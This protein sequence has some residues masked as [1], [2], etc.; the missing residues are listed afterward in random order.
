[1]K[2]RN[3]FTLIELLVVIAIIGMLSSVVLVSLN[4]ARAKSR[5]SK[6]ISDLSQL[7]LAVEL[8]YDKYGSY[9]STGGSWW[10][11]GNP[12]YGSHDYSGVNGW[13]PNLAPEFIGEL[14]GDPNP[15]LAGGAC[16]LYNSNGVDYMII[17]HG[18]ME[19][20]C[21]GSDSDTTR[22]PGDE[23]NPTYIQQ[24]DRYC[25]EQPSIAVYSSGAKTW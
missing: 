22:D 19:A 17:T 18:T 21:D 3:G 4:P 13:I 1:M 12:C 8:Y 2:I 14:P 11:E 10:G 15:N 23:C 9:P 6:R 7:Q 25:C 5:D 16:Y 24:K 20:I